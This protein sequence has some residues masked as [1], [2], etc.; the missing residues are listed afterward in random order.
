M[1]EIRLPNEREGAIF[2]V[3]KDD[4]VLI[5]TVVKPNSGYFGH[6]RI[7]AGKMEEGETPAQTVF[8]EALEEMRIVCKRVTFLDTFEDSTLNNNFVRLHAFLVKEYLGEIYQTEDE[9]KKSFL[10]WVDLDIA[11]DCLY[12]ASSRLIL[13]LAKEELIKEGQSKD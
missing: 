5:E 9:K 12:L 4:R 11:Q 3:V 13:L 1:H 6:N 2:L 10:T 7:P 8:R